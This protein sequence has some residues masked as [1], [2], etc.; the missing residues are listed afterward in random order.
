MTVRSGKVAARH[1][2]KTKDKKDEDH[3]KC[4]VRWDD[5]DQESKNKDGPYCAA[6][7]SGFLL[8]GFR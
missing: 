3:D 4:E 8:S 1:K 7:V 6:F 5:C 2:Q